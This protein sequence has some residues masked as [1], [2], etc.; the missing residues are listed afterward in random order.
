[1]L[2]GGLWHGAGWTFVVWGGLHGMYLMVNHGWQA[3]RKKLGHDP[4]RATL[5]GTIAARLL[6]FLAVILA[7]VFFRAETMGAATAILKAMA[8][9]GE[10]IP[11][12]AAEFKG[13]ARQLLWTAGLLA[14]VW[15][16]PN[17]QH[18]LARFQPAWDSPASP[19]TAR[20]WEW[21]PNWR[22]AVTLSALFL[23]AVMHL[24]KITEFLYF[25]F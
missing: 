2:L 6:T 16:A 13:V 1:M 24:C 17:T 20:W 15:L 25:Q 3:L 8:R 4:G 10:I 18:I 7:W 23:V 5:P 11:G 14:I 9:V 12:G 22:W 21:R 19:P